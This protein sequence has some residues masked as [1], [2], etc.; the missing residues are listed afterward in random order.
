MAIDRNLEDTEQDPSDTSEC[1]GDVPERL[2]ERAFAAA[3]PWCSQTVMR[4][5][6]LHIVASERETPSRRQAVSDRGEWQ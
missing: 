5:D 3:C 6:G 4:S 2:H 1:I